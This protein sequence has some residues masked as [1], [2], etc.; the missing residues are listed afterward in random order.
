MSS[1][2]KRWMLQYWSNTSTTYY[3]WKRETNNEE[4]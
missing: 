4:N 1:D 3:C 2:S